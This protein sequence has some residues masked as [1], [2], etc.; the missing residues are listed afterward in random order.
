[1]AQD[2]GASRIDGAG[3]DRP[4]GWIHPTTIVL[5]YVLVAGAWILLS[6]KAV[7]FLAGED[8]ALYAELEVG[9]GLGFV[10]VTGVV[11]LLLLRRYTAR[12]EAA[13]AEARRMARFAELSPNPVIEF[14]PDGSPVSMNAAAL[15]VRE[16]AG[17]AI[18]RLLPPD[19]KDIVL[20]C[21][22][23]GEHVSSV[24]HTV[25]G[26][27]WRWA[28]F[29]ADPPVSAYGYGYDRTEETRLEIQV[30]QAARME[31]VGR[32]A[33]GVAHDLNNFLMAIGGFRALARMKLEESHPAQEELVGMGDQIEAAQDLVKKLMLI[34]RM[35]S[36]DENVTR[37]DLAAHFPG[38][39]S[40]VRHLLRYNIKLEVEV[41]PDGPCL[42]EVDVREL[43]QALLNLAS[44]AVDAMPSGGTLRLSLECGQEG[45][46]AIVVADTGEGIPPDVLPRIFDP[47]FTTK[48][49]GRGTGLG[50]ASVYSFATHS[51]GT[52]EVETEPGAGSRF[53]LLLPLAGGDE[54]AG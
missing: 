1:M 34:A 16:S 7:D 36:A 39:V 11:L 6:G 49:E 25:A 32:L 54:R 19:T 33:A 2:S 24:L 30:Q 52:V 50:L 48:E 43:E 27:S 41:P 9:K 40:T 47:F 22:A 35:R 31:S 29:P 8:H 44:N 45:Q 46:A 21:M 20:R 23:T 13:H 15:A 28:F 42:V 51:G 5:G 26:R 17:L 18:E 53:R 14:G 12:L 38:L 3:A 10:A 4:A 37:V